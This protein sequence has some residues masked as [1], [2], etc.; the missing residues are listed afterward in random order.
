MEAAGQEA[1][2]VE[3]L[4]VCDATLQ[5]RHQDN[6]ARITGKEISKIG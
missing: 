6:V 5:H 1:L 2:W 3:A 4:E